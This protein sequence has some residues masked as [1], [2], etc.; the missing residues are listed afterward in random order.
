LLGTTLHADENVLPTWSGNWL[1][2]RVRLDPASACSSGPGDVFCALAASSREPPATGVAPVTFWVVNATALAQGKTLDCSGKGPDCLR[3]ASQSPIPPDPQFPLRSGFV[4]DTLIL[5][6]SPPEDN[7]QPW[8]GNTSVMV[9]RRGWAAARTLDVP[10]GSR[11]LPTA[12][13]GFI[14]CTRDDTSYRRSVYVGPLTEMLPAPALLEEFRCDLACSYEW[15]FAVSPDEQWAVWPAPSASLLSLELHARRLA[16]RADP[17]RTVVLPGSVDVHT[18]AFAEGSSLF[19]L[20]R[21]KNDLSYVKGSLLRTSLPPGPAPESIASEVT[22]FAVLPGAK[23]GLALITQPVLPTPTNIVPTGTL[24]LAPN[25]ASPTARA[26]IDDGVC[27]LDGL[28]AAFDVA[29]YSKRCPPPAMIDDYPYVVPAQKLLARLDPA[30]GAV[31]GTPCALTTG[32]TAIV[33]QMPSLDRAGRAAYWLEHQS[34][35]GFTAHVTQ[36]DGCRTTAL[37]PSDLG[38]WQLSPP[39]GFLDLVRASS[40]SMVRLIDVRGATPSIVEVAHGVKAVAIGGAPA[41]RVM[42][43]QSSTSGPLG[44]GLWAQPAP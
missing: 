43:L 28:S 20:R 25:A 18:A 17:A 13:E 39:T 19:F 34:Q 30:S 3:L 10:R 12:R 31:R 22:A 42:V 1:R 2:T 23:P 29:L 26:K 11:C 32:A 38:A 14:A 41:G 35:G 15:L 37:G 24:W 6:V 9:W 36:L 4:G 33:A 40:S 27:G 21:D 16:D 5:Y 8:L 44:S 7:V